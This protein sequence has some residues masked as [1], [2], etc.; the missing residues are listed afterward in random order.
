MGLSDWIYMLGIYYIL[1][2]ML[3]IGLIS[4]GY[5]AALGETILFYS[6]TAGSAA[7]LAGLLSIQ[8]EMWKS[9]KDL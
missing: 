6:F 3:V 7:A 4:A 2:L 8:P 5:S 1:M 9:W